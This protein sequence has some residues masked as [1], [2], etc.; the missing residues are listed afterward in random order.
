[1]LQT[2]TNNTALPFVAYLKRRLYS[3]NISVIKQ[4]RGTVAIGK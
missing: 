2:K 1:M 3:T 4:S